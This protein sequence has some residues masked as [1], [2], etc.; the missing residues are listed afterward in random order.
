MGWQGEDRD[1]GG[2]ADHGAPDSAFSGAAPFARDPR[3]SGF[4]HGGEWDSCP[5]SASLAVVLE[6]ACGPEWRCPEARHDELLGLLRQWQAL[7]AW[8]VAGKLGVL[9][10]LVREDDQPLPG[11]GFHGDLPNGWSK[12]LTH[13]VALALAMP[14]QS[15]EK[16]MW[17]AWELGA[18]LPGTADLL[19]RGAITYAKTRAVDDALAPLTDADAA[20]AEALI[21]PELPGKTYGQVEKLAVAAAMSVDPGAAARRREDAE[22]NRARVVLR[23]DPSGAAS[24]A[25]DDLPTAQSLA[26]HAN[27]CARAL[28]Y[29][30]SGRFPG[31]RMDQL[32]ALA[33]LDLMNGVTADARIAFGQPSAGLGAP[34]EYGPDPD[35]AAGSPDGSPPDDTTPADA[36]PSGRRPPGRHHPGRHHPG[37]AARSTPAA[38]AGRPGHSARDAA[39]PGRATGGGPRPRPPRPGSVPFPGRSGG[40]QPAQHLLRHHYRR[41]WHRHR[42]RLRPPGPPRPPLPR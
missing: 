32:R 35:P 27:V 12:S 33:Y 13:E 10:A 29:Q 2:G 6:A 38:P 36:R 25:G 11:G 37:L 17:T 30:E 22:R 23:R 18:R 20:A 3:L 41:Q 5:P 16:L 8:A 24:L 9:R 28:A 39:R 42:P 4:A 19:A 26:A 34:S 7:E 15:A 31:A 14:P 40:R 21:V 1:A